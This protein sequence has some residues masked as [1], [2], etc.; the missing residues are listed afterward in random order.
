MAVLPEPVAVGVPVD[1]VA[2]A[3]GE[4]V[5]SEEV[6]VSYDCCTVGTVSV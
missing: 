3:D 5:S 4:A 2:D 1:P 6:V